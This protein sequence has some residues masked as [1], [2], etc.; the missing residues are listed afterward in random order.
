MLAARLLTSQSFAGSGARVPFYLQDTLGGNF[1]M[2]SYPSYR[3]RGDKVLTL[4]AEY[5]FE[6]TPRYELA[7]FYDTGKAWDDNAFS[8]EGLKSSYGLGFRFKATDAALV[9]LEVA[10]GGEGTRALLKLGYSF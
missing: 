9:R 4:S 6:L 1:T 10:H 8:L 7:A 3:F 5:R 2:R